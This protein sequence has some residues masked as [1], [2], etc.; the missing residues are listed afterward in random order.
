M[1]ADGLREIQYPAYREISVKHINRLL[2][3]SLYCIDSIGHR[4]PDCSMCFESIKVEFFKAYYSVKEKKVKLIGR[5]SIPEVGVYSSRSI[6]GIP[7]DSP[8][9]VTT[10]VDG[11]YWN[12]EYFDLTVPADQGSFLTFYMPQCYAIRYNVGALTTTKLD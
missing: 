1:L 8:K 5:T 12:F 4:T 10:G 2:A 6:N 11:K 3:E 7:I 9:C